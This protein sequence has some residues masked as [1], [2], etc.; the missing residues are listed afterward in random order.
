MNGAEFP[1]EEKLSKIFQKI[2]RPVAPVKIWS[3]FFSEWITFSMVVDTGADYTIL[4]IYN[5]LTLGID[6]NKDCRKLE[7]IGIG[8]KQTVYFYNKKIKIKIGDCELKIPVGFA[9]SGNI[10]AIL[11]R[12]GCL[13]NFKLTFHN[14][15]TTFSSR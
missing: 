13:D 10:P 15:K 6:I 12:Q 8:G 1:Y 14:F 2:K 3:S 9:Q 11:G 5:A 7:T 4:S